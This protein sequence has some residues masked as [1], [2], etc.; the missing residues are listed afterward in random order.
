MN[1]KH[2]AWA[3][4]ATVVMALVAGGTSPAV[5]DSAKRTVDVG[6]RL[7]LQPD[8][9][10]RSTGDFLGT[11]QLL[12]EVVVSSTPVGEY[13]LKVIK[14]TDKLTGCL[15]LNHN[16]KCDRG[17]PRGS[18]TMTYQRVATFDRSGKVFIESYCS[19]PVT[20]VTN[21]GRYTKFTSGLIF[22]ADRARD[23]KGGDVKS[24]YRGTLSLT[25]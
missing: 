23:G 19:H 16:K 18:V 6:G 13:T 14:G 12:T 3:A 20:S 2:L 7:Y 25:E 4:T 17:G 24:T 1:S 15:D 8:G 10:W 11:Y 9:S 22:M 21:T 5:A